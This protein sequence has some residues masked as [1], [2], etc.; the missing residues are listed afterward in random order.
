MLTGVRSRTVERERKGGRE[1]ER[2]VSKISCLYIQ[3]TSNCLHTSLLSNSQARDTTDS[4][5]GKLFVHRELPNHKHCT[6]FNNPQ[7]TPRQHEQRFF[8]TFKLLKRESRGATAV[9]C[10][11]Q[12]SAVQTAG[13]PICRR[14]QGLYADVHA[15][16]CARVRGCKG[17]ACCTRAPRPATAQR[18]C[19][20]RGTARAHAPAYALF[21]SASSRQCML[22]HSHSRS[23]V[24]KHPASGRSSSCFKVSAIQ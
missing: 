11:S 24:E 8:F 16:K 21:T 7:R 17:L 10:G 20:Y 1:G 5:L 3:G 14:A 6:C 12:A 4:S 15:A 13:A 19:S 18:E 2:L 9:D 23:A 22:C